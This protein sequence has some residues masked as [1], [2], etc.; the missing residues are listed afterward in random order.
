MRSKCDNLKKV[1]ITELEMNHTHAL[2]NVDYKQKHKYCRELD[3]GPSRIR[4][5]I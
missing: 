5:H 1:R 4:K 3:Y 2:C